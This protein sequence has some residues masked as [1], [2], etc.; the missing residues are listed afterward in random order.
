M[1]HHIIALCTIGN[2]GEFNVC[3]QMRLHGTLQVLRQ[4][5]HKWNNPKI[6]LLLSV[7][8]TLF[9]I[10]FTAITFLTVG[11]KLELSQFLV[12]C[13]DIEFSFALHRQHKEFIKIL[14]FRSPW[15]LFATSPSALAIPHS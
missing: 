9:E 12:M 15:T 4:L 13:I 2:I 10:T 7:A 8:A 6:S 14:F 3:D 1:I 5:L 11:I